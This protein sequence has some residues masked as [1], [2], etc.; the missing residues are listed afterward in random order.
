MRIDL[1]NLLA[2]IDPDARLLDHWPLTGGVSAQTLAVEFERS[3]G[4]AAHLVVRAH[5]PRDLARDPD[6]A[7]HEYMLL[8]ALFDSGFPV[9]E[10]VYVDQHGQLSGRPAVVSGFLAGEARTA[11]GPQSTSRMISEMAFWLA[12]IHRFDRSQVDL[13]F[14]VGSDYE[15]RSRLE[16]RAEDSALAQRT[17]R[18]LQESPETR[19]LNQPVLLHGD[20]WRGN[21]LWRSERIVGIIDW[22]DAFIGDPIIDL[23]RTRLELFWTE[24]ALASERFTVQYL[25]W[26]DIDIDGLPWWDLR[27]SLEFARALPGWGLPPE[28]EREMLGL[29]EQFVQRAVDELN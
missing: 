28:R 15:D 1:Q 17:C 21:L 20:F 3:D 22:E 5:G 2:A 9:A 23:A 6:I 26:N 18:I 14:L 16:S 29:L 19:H 7:L 11:D 8:Q 27:M 13:S 10:P 12:K 24:G 25:G 4:S